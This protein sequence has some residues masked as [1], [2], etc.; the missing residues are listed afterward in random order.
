MKKILLLSVSALLSGAAGTLAAQDI[1]MAAGEK[2][3]NYISF[4]E[5]KT[6]NF[7]SFNDGKVLFAKTVIA[8]EATEK[9]AC[10]CDPS[11]PSF[12]AAMTLDQNG[13]IVTMNMTGTKLFRYKASEGVQT[14]IIG[15]VAKADEQKFFA[16]MTTTPDGSI[17]ALNNDGS[18]LLRING[19]QTTDLGAV[20]GFEAIFRNMADTRSSFG[21]DMIADEAGNLLVITAFGHIV[22]IVPSI[23]T[24]SYIGQ[25][26]ALPEGYTVNG[27]AVTET[28]EVLLASS[29]PKGLYHLNMN[30]LNATFAGENDNPAYDLASNNFLKD[31]SA[32]IAASGSL[33]ISPTLIGSNKTFNIASETALKNITVSIYSAEGKLVQREAKNLT[34][35]KNVIPVNYLSSGIYLVNLTNEKGVKLMSEKITVE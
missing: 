28:G 20:E 16:R 34:A 27:A 18:R 15:E 1:Y 7:N 17:Y 35:G 29:Q 4:K 26:A 23:L 14:T 32:N 6:L 19:E 11:S 25:I 24:A 9:S 31:K 8:P 30:T 5:V 13:N 22:K 3:V 21:G 33:G 2:N 10:G 12:I